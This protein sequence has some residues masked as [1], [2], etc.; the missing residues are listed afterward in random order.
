MD[1]DVAL[2]SFLFCE[3]WLKV[4]WWFWT[5]LRMLGRGDLNIGFPYFFVQLLEELL[6]L[7][8]GGNPWL[9]FVFRSL[10]FLLILLSVMNWRLSCLLFFRLPGHLRWKDMHSPSK[11]QLALKV[12]F[13]ICHAHPRFFVFGFCFLDFLFFF[14]LFLTF[15]WMLLLTC[16]LLW[17]LWRGGRAEFYRRS[18]LVGSLILKHFAELLNTR[19]CYY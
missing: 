17:L 14:L 7:P 12:F 4:C 3:V 13:Q 5:L 15:L 9:L 2:F 16:V 1:I 18:I 6:R 19:H 10:L 8:K 11:V